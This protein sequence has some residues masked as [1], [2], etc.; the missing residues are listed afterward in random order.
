MDFREYSGIRQS[1]RGVIID[2]VFEDVFQSSHFS[3]SNLIFL[4][5]RPL[6]TCV[7]EFSRPSDEA[8]VPFGF[9]MNSLENCDIGAALGRLTTSIRRPSDSIWSVKRRHI[10]DGG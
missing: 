7:A 2:Y 3:M 1:S 8:V 5:L 4:T 6:T 9:P 10:G